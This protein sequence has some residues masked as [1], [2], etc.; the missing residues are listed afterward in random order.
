M[1]VFGVMTE[2]VQTMPPGMPAADAPELI[3]PLR[4]S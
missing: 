4:T 3:T 2:G 1:R